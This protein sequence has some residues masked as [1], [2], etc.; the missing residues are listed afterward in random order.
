MAISARGITLHWRF[1]ILSFNKRNNNMSTNIFEPEVVCNIQTETTSTTNQLVLEMEETDAVC[2][3]Y[4]DLGV[5]ETQWGPKHQCKFVF[6]TRE[7]NDKGY[8]VMIQRTFTK[9]LHEKSALKPFIENWRGYELSPEE[10]GGKL[11]LDKMVG[12]PASIK[13]Q[14]SISKKGYAFLKLLAIAPGN[15]KLQASGAYKRFEINAHKNN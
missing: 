6:E 15:V 12:K 10:I 4:I 13:Y 2:V 11:K 5:Q 9:S 14:D 3:D 1:F 8:P 7:T